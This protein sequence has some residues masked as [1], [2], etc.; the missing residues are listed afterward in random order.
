V[1]LFSFISPRAYLIEISRNEIELTK[2]SFSGSVIRFNSLLFSLLLSNKMK[3]RMFVSMSI[4]I[5][6]QLV[7]KKFFV[8]DF[9]IFGDTVGG[10]SF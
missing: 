3:R 10:F 8:G 5:L 9:E 7:G 6:I 1:I 2:M 4:F